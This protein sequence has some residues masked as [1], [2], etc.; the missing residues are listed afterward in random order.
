LRKTSDVAGHEDLSREQAADRFHHAPALLLHC[1]EIAPHPA[2]LCHPLLRAETARD[3][4]LH[5]QL[6]QVTFRLV[7]SSRPCAASSCAPE[8]EGRTKLAAIAMAVSSVDYQRF[9]GIRNGEGCPGSHQF[10]LIS[11]FDV[12]SPFYSRALSMK[13]NQNLHKTGLRVYRNRRIGPNIP[14]ADIDLNLFSRHQVDTLKG[15]RL[16]FDES[17][18]GIK[19]LCHYYRSAR[20]KQ[21]ADSS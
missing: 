20:K 3:L 1:R 6:P 4:L 18:T 13:I 14:I 8:G 19:A 12:E 2:Q 7:V 9:I 16:K 10:T 15:F 11:G 21:L 5:L 17:E